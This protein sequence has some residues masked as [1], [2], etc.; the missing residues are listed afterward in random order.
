M[1]KYKNLEASYRFLM[2]KQNKGSASARAQNLLTVVTEEVT[3]AEN[4]TGA[5]RE[6]SLCG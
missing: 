3:S 1:L 2:K 5:L 6:L 4:P